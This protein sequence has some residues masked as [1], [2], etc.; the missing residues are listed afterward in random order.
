MS[1]LL[2]TLPRHVKTPPKLDVDALYRQYGAMV[3]RRCR[4]LRKDEELARDA[5]QDT[6]TRL[7]QHADTLEAPSPGGLLYRIA[8]N[9][10]LLRLRTKRRHPES[11]D[12]VALAQAP[13][14]RSS[15]SD[16]FARAVLAPVFAPESVSTKRTVVL[17]RR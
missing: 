5:M 2:E 12:E 3:L 6:F 1:A 14:T 8:T 4:Q 9:T 7:Q 17:H 16:G 11:F 13:D 10:S 15:T